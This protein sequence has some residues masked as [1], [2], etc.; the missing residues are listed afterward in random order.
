ME[1]KYK[2]DANKNYMILDVKEG[3]DYQLRMLCENKIKGLLSA[4]GSTFDGKEELYYEISSKQPIS[5]IYSKKQMCF[6]DIKRIIFGMDSLFREIKKYLLESSHILLGPDYC[7]CSPDSNKTE[8]VFYPDDTTNN[9]MELAEFFLEHVDHKDERGVELAYKFFKCAREENFVLQEIIL[10]VEE[11][12]KSEEVKEEKTTVID[13]EEEVLIPIR[14]NVFEEKESL[15][16]KMKTIIRE[17]TTFFKDKHLPVKSGSD[18]SMMSVEDWESFAEDKGHYTG[19][20]TVIGI[21]NERQKHRMRSLN[22]K[23]GE[24]LII[25]DF[26]CVFGKMAAQTDIILAGDGISRMHAKIYEERGCVYLQD[27]N[28]TNG[29]FKN[30]VRLEANETVPLTTGDEVGFARLRYIYE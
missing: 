20:T 7:Y 12:E 16:N 3:M 29:T 11:L 8:W 17:K 9:F 19:E 1:I 23:N 26:P 10:Y 18:I 4:H 30:G 27:L 15:W 24:N 28:S 2:R 13:E 22:D 25:Q 21:S 6:E 14:E 5:R